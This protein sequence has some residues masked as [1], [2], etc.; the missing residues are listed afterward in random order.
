MLYNDLIVIVSDTFCRSSYLATISKNSFV[1]D[2][3]LLTLILI[4]CVCVRMLMFTV[5]VGEDRL[6]S[7][8]AWTAGSRASL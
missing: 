2:M 5:P 7:A 8:G 1:S 3:R 4:S 6:E